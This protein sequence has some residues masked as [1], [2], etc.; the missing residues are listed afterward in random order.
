[1]LPW[2]GA[3]S[4]ILAYVLQEIWRNMPS[5]EFVMLGHSDTIH[6]PGGVQVL[7]LCEAGQGQQP[8]WAR[9]PAGTATAGTAYWL[10][11]STLSPNHA[12]LADVQDS[13]RI[14]L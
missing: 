1:M 6:T 8:S 13:S 3:C 10:Q 5:Q 7:P 4:S 12:A 9:D 14:V 2:V 11:W